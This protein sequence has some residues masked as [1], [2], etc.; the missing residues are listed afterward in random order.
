MTR[1]REVTT[2]VC[3]AL[4]LAALALALLGSLGCQTVEGFGR[5]VTA[6]GQALSNDQP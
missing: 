4:L 1:L 3:M 5:D 2:N 6:L